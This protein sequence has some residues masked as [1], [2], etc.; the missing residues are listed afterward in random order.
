[1]VL[2]ARGGAPGLGNQIMAGSRKHRSMSP[3]KLPGAHGESREFE[4]ELKTIAD[5]GLVGYPNAGKSTLLGIMSHAKPETA[6]YPFTTLH[7]QVG[8]LEYSDARQVTVADIPGL[9]DGAHLNRGLGHEFLR[10]I[11]R[12]KALVYVVDVAGTEGRDPCQDLFSLREELFLYDETLPL[13]PSLVV[14]NKID[15]PGAEENLAKLQEAAAPLQV[16]PVCAFF[17]EGVEHVAIQVR[18]LVELAETLPK[19]PSVLDVPEQ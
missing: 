8:H 17:G 13:K 2:A 15:E 9:I 14:A 5:V 7:P 10:H 12:T 6:A 4:L 1:M 16:I 18:E 19:L 11:E 3:K